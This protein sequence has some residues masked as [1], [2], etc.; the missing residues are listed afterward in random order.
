MLIGLLIPFLQLAS[1]A[2]ILNLMVFML[3]LVQ[4]PRTPTN[5]A[6]LFN[7]GMLQYW[8]VYVVCAL[9]FRLFVHLF[10]VWWFTCCY[11][12]ETQKS[13]A[14]LRSRVPQRTLH[15]CLIQNKARKAATPSPSLTAIQKQENTTQIK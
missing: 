13:Y 10:I 15:V 3:L 4:I 7:L 2:V 11:K 8:N 14:C 5:F 6:C 1:S 12:R 9:L